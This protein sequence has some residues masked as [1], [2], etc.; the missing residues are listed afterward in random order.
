MRKLITLILL[1]MLCVAIRA[2]YVPDVLG[3]GYLCRTI[4]MPDDYEGKVVCTLVKKTSLPKAEQAVLYIHGYNDYFFQRELG[5]SVNA[6]GYDFYALDLRKY[7]RSIL[8]HQEPFSCRSLTEYFADID[9]ALQL[10]RSEKHKQVFLMGHSTGGL[11]VSYYMKK[12]MRLDRR[13]WHPSDVVEG[14][15]LNS[16]FL[17]WN[18]GW[19][20]EEAVIPAVAW[21]GKH[22]PDWTV[23]SGGNFSQYAASLLKRYRGEWDYNTD[24]KKEYDAPK[25]AGWVRAICVAQEELRTLPSLSVPVLLLS[26]DQSCPE[27]KEWNND[28]KRSDI[29]L[30]VDDIQKYGN[31]L[32][33]DLTRDTIPGGM[34]DLILSEPLVRKRAY[35]AILDWLDARPKPRSFPFIYTVPK[36]QSG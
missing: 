10:I 14:L 29:V 16:P 23:D 31:C 9:T 12:Q 8:P 26:S 7:G 19:F 22:F 4:E 20:M 6:H 34:H 17:D 1:C 27:T 18:F 11:I 2:Q 33:Q 13:I 28:Y 15:V 36:E 3:D 5:D 32:S 35:R 21:L 30:D 24:W 25:K